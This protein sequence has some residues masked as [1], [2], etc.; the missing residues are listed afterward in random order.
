MALVAVFVRAAIPAGY[1]V[2][3][4][5]GPQLVICSGHA[6]GAAD[7]AGKPVQDR[8]KP[9]LPCAF[10]GTHVALHAPAGPDLAPWTRIA[11][12]TVALAAPDLAPGRGLAA[13]PPPSTGPPVSL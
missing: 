9:D 2:A 1:M 3:Q 6:V 5:H 4:A 8:H 11:R 7:P 13:P 12:E 10:A